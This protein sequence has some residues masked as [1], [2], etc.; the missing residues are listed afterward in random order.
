MKR[1]KVK[2]TETSW[3]VAGIGRNGMN[4][5]HAPSCTNCAARSAEAIQNAVSKAME[6]VTK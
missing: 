4:V 6:V 5:I 3:K 2:V 1:F